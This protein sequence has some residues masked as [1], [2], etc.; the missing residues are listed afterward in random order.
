MKSP[1]R[2][3]LYL[4]VLPE[5]TPAA[6]IDALVGGDVAAVE[7]AGADA[8]LIAAARRQGIAVLLR[9]DVRAAAGADGVYLADP[10]ADVAAARAA[11]GP[12]KIVGAFAG[13]S[14]HAAMVVGEAGVD[15]VAFDGDLDTVAWWAE[16]MVV[17]CLA[18]GDV[19]IDTI[20]AAV[21]AGADFIAVDRAVWS[22]PDGPRAA[23]AALNDAV[24]RAWAL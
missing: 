13:G 24:D 4:I 15:F 3:R 8:G 21:A 22:H 5:T 1:E 14:R 18:R 10:E 9:D 23:I 6:L 20:A 17:P 2:P 7:L 16:T 12:E 19:T 11:L